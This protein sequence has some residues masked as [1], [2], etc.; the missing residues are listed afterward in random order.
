MRRLVTQHEAESQG[1][2]IVDNPATDLKYLRTLRGLA[3][4]PSY[5][6]DGVDTGDIDFTQSSLFVIVS[7]LVRFAQD[8]EY[9][10]LA[11]LRPGNPQNPGGIWNGIAGFA[12]GRGEISPLTTVFTELYEEAA[13]LPPVIDRVVLG[14]IE[15]VVTSQGVDIIAAKA[16]VELRQRPDVVI[17]DEH[18]DFAWL[19]D[20]DYAA[21]SPVIPLAHIVHRDFIDY[22]SR[23][24]E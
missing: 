22:P 5:K 23:L 8:G 11:M 14:G 1:V 19:S 21:M 7:T 2:E 13:I 10:N 15:R 6:E 12:M 18:L 4:I 16:L 3:S 17:N 20:E 24:S 9:M